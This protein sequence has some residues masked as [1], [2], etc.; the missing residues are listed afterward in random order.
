M[1][2][3]PFLPLS[4]R[5][6][7]NDEKSSNMSVCRGDDLTNGAYKFVRSNLNFYDYCEILKFSS[8]CLK[9]VKHMN[10]L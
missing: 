8:S 6:L 5:K 2:C 7:I 1:S 4:N 10:K 9:Y 3:F